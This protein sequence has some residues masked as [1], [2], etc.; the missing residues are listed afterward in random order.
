MVLRGS[1]TQAAPSVW[2]Y[3]TVALKEL[4]QRWQY[5][6]DAE[7]AP[8]MRRPSIGQKPDWN[9]CSRVLRA[10]GLGSQTGVWI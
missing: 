4:R 7:R 10:G 9:G 1:Y 6:G 3:G 8:Y 5:I 2:G